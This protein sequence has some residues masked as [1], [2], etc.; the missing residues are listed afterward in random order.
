MRH[1]TIKYF[2]GLQAYGPIWQAMRDFTQQRRERAIP[3]NDELWLLEHQPVF[4]QGQAGKPEHILDSHQIPIIHCDRGGQVTYHGPGQL[5]IYTLFDLNALG[6][7]T[8]DFVRA[9]ENCIITYLKTLDIAAEG[10]TEAPGVYVN[11]EKICSIGLRVQK[12]YSYHGLALNIA[13][14]LTPFHSINPCGYQGLIMTQLN[15]FKACTLIEVIDALI[16]TICQEFGY[17]QWQRQ[18]ITL[19]EQLA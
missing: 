4:T 19:T 11:N 8:R 16:P 5:M 12:G 10:K 7:R 3:C 18:T 17:N 2:P 6:L 1:L 13:M 9:L 14:D 15:H